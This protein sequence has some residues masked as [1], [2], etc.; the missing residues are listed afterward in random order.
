[1]AARE[2]RWT[3]GLYN[4]Y[5]ANHFHETM[6]RAIAR[7]APLCHA[8]G[9]NLSP[10]GFPFHAYRDKEGNAPARE[11]P[12]VIAQLVA[13]STSIGE[14]GEYLETLATEGRFQPIPFPAK[15]F[16]PQLGTVVLATRKPDPKKRADL[17]DVAFRTR[18][19]ESFLFLVGLGP[20][21]VP[22][23]VH[24]QAALHLEL[25]G[26]EKSLE[27]ATAMG[28]LAGRLHE[29]ME[30][31]VR[32]VNRALTTDALVLRGDEVLL[33]KRGRE[34][35][36]GRWALP[37]GFVDADETVE[38]TCIREVSEETGVTGRVRGL[39]GVY[40]RPGRDPRGQTVSL[41]FHV[42]ATGGEPK[43]GDDASEARFFSWDSLPALAFDHEEMLRD[44]RKRL[45]SGKQQP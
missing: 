21:G 41:L 2:G 8:F 39:L 18:E 29:V 20:R 45:A 44:A 3:L 22:K 27:T 31:I 38:E 33:I 37:G 1:M 26:S 24:A 9:M 15:G 40:S 16:P 25:T 4:S 32:P 30:S 42:E 11:T 12:Q 35:F 28:V 6:R 43:A 19:G 14:G 10:I 7:A 23:D 13:S 17:R 5:D 36:K 34:P